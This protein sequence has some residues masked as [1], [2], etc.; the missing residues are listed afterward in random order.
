MVDDEKVGRGSVVGGVDLHAEGVEVVSGRVSLEREAVDG[1]GAGDV[2]KEMTAWVGIPE[3]THDGVP[4]L[5]VGVAA[6][7][8]EAVGERAVGVVV[9]PKGDVLAKFDVIGGAVFDEGT[10]GGPVA[11]DIVS[12]WEVGSGEDVVPGNTA[13][14]VD[15][16]CLS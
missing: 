3:G 11:A 16:D 4:S 6:E 2:E 14:A 10:V 9:I 1:V 8:N 7:E 13:S 15:E 12:T 5:S